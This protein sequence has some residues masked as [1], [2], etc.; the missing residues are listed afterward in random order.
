MSR[1]DFSSEGGR[2]LFYALSH[3]SESKFS[4]FLESDFQSKRFWESNKL[5]QQVSYPAFRGHAAEMAK[6]AIAQMTPEAK[7]AELARIAKSLQTK[8][9]TPK[10]ST[11]STMVKHDNPQPTTVKVQQSSNSR[12]QHNNNVPSLRD[13]IVASHPNGEMAIIIFE[14]DGDTDEKACQLQ[15]AKKGQKIKIY[16]RIPTELTN[17]ASLLGT[18]EKRSSIKDADCMLLDLAI[19]KRLEGSRKDANGDFWEIRE[20]IDLPF[21]CKS[22]IFNKHRKEIP[23]YLL[24]KNDQGYAW[25]YF[26]VVASHVGQREKGPTKILCQSTSDSESTDND[27]NQSQLFS[28]D[29]ESEDNADEMDIEFEA[30][31]DSPKKQSAW[32]QDNVKAELVRLKE[33]LEL[34]SN[35][36]L[37]LKS[38]SDTFLNIT[39]PDLKNQVQLKNEEI[40]KLKDNYMCEMTSLRSQLELEQKRYM[41]M[42]ACNRSE[43]EELLRKLNTEREQVILKNEELVKL[44]DR[45]TSEINDIKHLL[46]EQQRKC[47]I[48]EMKEKNY[49]KEREEYVRKINILESA[50][51]TQEIGNKTTFENCRENFTQLELEIQRLKDDNQSKGKLIKELRSSSKSKVRDQQAM[52]AKLAEMEKALRESN[53]KFCTLQNET[54]VQS[55]ISE[56]K[57]KESIGNI[58]D[59]QKLL[60]EKEQEYI[61]QSDQIERL[62]SHVFQMEQSI[63]Q[64]DSF[65]NTKLQEVHGL[66]THIL[67]QG[68]RVKDLEKEL[69]RHR[70]SKNNI[71]LT[72]RIDSEED[73][74]LEFND[75]N[76]WDSDKSLKTVTPKNVQSDKE[77]SFDASQNTSK[78][79][80]TKAQNN[81]QQKD[82]LVNSKQRGS[83]Q[84]IETHGI[85]SEET[86]QEGPKSAGVDS[87]G[88]NHG[89]SNAEVEEKGS[90][91][92]DTSGKQTDSE[93]KS[94]QQE[95]IQRAADMEGCKGGTTAD[96][97][98]L[99]EDEGIQRAADVAGCEGGTTADDYVLDEDDASD[100]PYDRSGENNK[101]NDIFDFHEANHVA[102]DGYVEGTIG[103]SIDTLAD[104]TTSV[105]NENVETDGQ[106]SNADPVENDKVPQTL[107]KKLSKKRKSVT[108][109]HDEHPN[110]KIRKSK[111]LEEKRLAKLMKA[112][113]D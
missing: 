41:D 96:D 53:E 63:L 58:Q 72:S 108:D 113:M 105:T 80:P 95:G 68:N 44:K 7:K 98:V 106:M 13:T 67:H 17:A 109:L 51:Q 14:L 78:V 77:A 35:E 60:C 97:Y 76:R 9:A 45:Y 5:F 59:L 42:E 19:K 79:S 107:S 102:S 22:S 50:L 82:D 110:K 4:P 62:Q 57:L 40:N 92:I 104:V 111:R 71:R 8:A 46:A 32:L 91:S 24:R 38:A 16:S 11:S 100:Q 29:D 2:V 88:G 112:K 37:R 56:S 85:L 49:Q 69:E 43:K 33:S 18:T 64:K 25:G 47:I 83:S 73:K 94:V 93:Q 34:K 15:F 65:I 12:E 89:C 101:E 23:T 84:P 87:Q 10:K 52:E 66:K 75:L 39:I 61:Y 27:E 86:N 31:D 28:S 21:Q 26:W 55:E 30:A 3:P 54:A 74:R 99:D 36:A 48:V 70:N 20:I 103:Q 1:L 6:I 81:E 90:P